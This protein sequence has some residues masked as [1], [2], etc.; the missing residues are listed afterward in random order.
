[1]VA[2]VA[3]RG[4]D[5]Q[6]YNDQGIVSSCI[7]YR[8]KVDNPR[9]DEI[10]QALQV[11]II[12]SQKGHDI[13]FPK[14]GWESDETIEG[15]ASRS[16]GG[17]RRQLGMWVFKSKTKDSCKEGYMFPM[18]VTMELHVQK[19]CKQQWMKE[20]LDKLVEQLLAR[21]SR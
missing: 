15:A 1:M 9:R 17:S 16:R 14:G 2:L 6:R 12:S 10:G 4:R 13:M 5:L 7:P 21:S 19:S 20:A 3:R 8:L 11:L 18:R